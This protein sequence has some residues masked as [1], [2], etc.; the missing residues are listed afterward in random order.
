MAN[1]RLEVIGA[2]S[3]FSIN[4]LSSNENNNNSAKFKNKNED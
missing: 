3:S 4:K 2:S 1:S